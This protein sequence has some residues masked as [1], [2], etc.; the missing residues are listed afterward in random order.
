VLLFKEFSSIAEKRKRA[1]FREPFSF[2]A[3]IRVT[4]LVQVQEPEDEAVV[5]HRESFGPPQMRQNRCAE[6]C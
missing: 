3:A 2:L 6:W 5:N 1:F 4:S